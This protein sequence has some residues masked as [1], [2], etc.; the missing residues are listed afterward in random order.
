MLKKSHPRPFH[1]IVGHAILAALFLGLGQLVYAASPLSQDTKSASGQGHAASREANGSY[2]LRLALS[3]DGQPVRLR[4]TECLKVDDYY[5]FSEKAADTLPAWHGR[6]TVVPAEE[7]ELE[8]RTNLSGG[9]LAKPV[10]PHIRMR[11]GQLGGI[12][13]GDTV[14]G[15]DGKS[16]D[17]TLKLELTAWAG[18]VTPPAVDDAG[19]VQF[20]FA[21][22]SARAVAQSIARQGGFEI[23]NPQVLDST[24]PVV[25]NFEQVPAADA[26][27][28]IGHLV[29]MK[30]VINGKQVRFEPE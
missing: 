25:G 26:F 20:N 28:L 16:D 12:Q 21:T 19:D 30:P 1:I 11:P 9:S 8:V 24:R 2:T 29:G 4:S 17:R 22:T 6:L 18:C 5:S 3:I 14:T 27:R 13:I 10:S 15:K 7:G 23:V